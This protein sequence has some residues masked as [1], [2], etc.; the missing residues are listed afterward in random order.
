[1][2]PLPVAPAKAP[3]PE[4]TLKVP[5]LRDPQTA[6]LTARRR[7]LFRSRVSVSLRVPTTLRQPAAG[8]APKGRNAARVLTQP[9]PVSLPAP[10]NAFL[11]QGESCRC[12]S[13]TCTPGVIAGAVAEARPVGP[14]SA[15]PAMVRKLKEVPLMCDR[16]YCESADIPRIV[17][18][19]R[20][21]TPFMPL[22]S[23]PI[24]G[25]LAWASVLSPDGERHRKCLA[26][27]CGRDAPAGRMFTPVSISVANVSTRTCSTAVR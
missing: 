25:A 24:R 16:G 4:E 1:M 12:A 22:F 9:N 17:R 19:G 2:T 26:R 10:Q 7:V 27:H 14:T 23:L 20:R 13:K 21:A 15:Q 18:A 8:G 3:P 11:P 6:P 5:Q